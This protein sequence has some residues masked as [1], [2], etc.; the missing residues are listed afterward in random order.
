MCLGWNQATFVKIDWLPRSLLIKAGA[1]VNVGA[2]D[3]PDVLGMADPK[4]E[5]RNWALETYFDRF[6][7]WKRTT[8]TSF[9]HF[10]GH[11]QDQT[12]SIQTFQAISTAKSPDLGPAWLHPP[13]LCAHGRSL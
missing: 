3:A 1:D 13:L 2:P 7:T 11:F 10:K 8:Q 6:D 4:D 5:K 12:R 9:S